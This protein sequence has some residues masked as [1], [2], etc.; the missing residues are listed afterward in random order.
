M[1]RTFRCSKLQYLLFFVIIIKLEKSPRDSK[2]KF[3]GSENLSVQ[4]TYENNMLKYNHNNANNKKY[5]S[6][7]SI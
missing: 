3:I 7:G 1:C 5:L 2:R 4:I 6:N